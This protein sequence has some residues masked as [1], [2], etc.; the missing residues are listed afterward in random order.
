MSNVLT[1][2][3]EQKILDF[4][5]HFA[6]S[7]YEV[8]DLA[9]H[10]SI[11]EQGTPEMRGEDGYLICLD[12]SGVGGIQRM[13][14]VLNEDGVIERDHTYTDNMGCEYC[15]FGNR[16]EY[17]PDEAE[18]SEANVA[19]YKERRDRRFQGATA[20]ALRDIEERR[21]Q[22]SQEQRYAA[23]Y[24]IL[25]GYIETMLTNFAEFFSVEQ[26]AQ[27]RM[28]LD[29]LRKLTGKDPSLD[30]GRKVKLDQPA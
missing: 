13:V 8:S 24:G 4:A 14:V 1:P 30:D 15:Q 10:L 6:R 7:R 2:A 27:I 29:Q 9:V 21:I 17:L 26:V 19:I 18:E 23:S 25:R 28:V 20:A 11:D 12:I 22:F 16:R 5:R 3:Q